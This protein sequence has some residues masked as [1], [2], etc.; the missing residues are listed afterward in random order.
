MS[1]V[2]V[3]LTT[4]LIL[5]FSIHSRADSTVR[6][7]NRDANQPIYDNNLQT[8]AFGPEYYVEVLAGPVGGVLSP[9][10][11]AGSTETHFPFTEPGYFD[12]G[13]GIIPGVM[14]GGPADFM[15]RAWKKSA[16]F[17]ADGLSAKW[18]QLTGS[19]NPVSGSPD[20][21][22]T[23]VLKIPSITVINVPVPEPATI[24]LGLL[25][26]TLLWGRQI[27]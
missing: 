5:V 21:A 10:T 12:A 8:P 17:V 2:F 23:P 20:A 27:G 4:G 18:T 16:D 9:I 25:G 14:D 6:L 22:S 3:L 24:A 15:I 1:R 19:W 7:N 11:L 13:V 26:L